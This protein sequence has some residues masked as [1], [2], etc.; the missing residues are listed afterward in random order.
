MANQNQKS[1][2]QV[3]RETRADRRAAEAAE[4]ARKAEQEAAE[5][6]QQTIIGAIVVAIVVV[7]VAIAGFA[8][9][10]ATHPTQKDT[11]TSS[12]VTLED[13]YKSLQDVKTTPKHADDN[14][15]IVISKEGY[16][17]KVSGAPT[18]EFY[19]EPIC[20]GCGS[21]HRQLD[22]SLV[23][24]VK[25]GQ[26]N[27]DLHFLTFG[28]S[29]SSDAYSTRAFNGAAYISDH[30]DD[31]M[32]LLSFL[33]NI[34]A[35][36]FQPQEGSSY[37]SVSNDQLKEQAVKAGVSEDVASAAF[38]GTYDYQS[39][40]SAA[41]T[42][43]IRR[44]EL[45]G[46]GTSFSSPTLAI[47]GKFWDFRSDMNE[48]SVKMLDALLHAIGLDS[49]KVGVSGTMPSIGSDGEAIAY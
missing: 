39:W 6:K 9:F 18:V 27:L 2:Q 24:M 17:K 47:N 13:A 35:E 7:L 29:K 32:H 15:G 30:D 48:K 31:P 26:I 1:K 49:S 44:T 38:N 23:K 14:A 21:V 43:T 40:L 16:D 22:E 42:Y 12:S 10:K 46:T 41:N 5:R 3:K 20:P 34:Y 33:E 36:D 28:D 4:A 8:I 45:Y 11:T 19:M 25:A 37:V